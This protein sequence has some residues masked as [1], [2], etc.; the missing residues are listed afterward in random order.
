[1]VKLMNSP[2]FII[3]NPR[4]G[5]TLLRL[6][7]TCHKNILIPPECG[8][9][10][11]W[12]VKYK[13]WGEQGFDENLLFEFIQDLM[14][15]RKIETWGINPEEL[16]KFIEERRPSSYSGL[17]SSVYDWYG[18]SQGKK[19]V[20]WGD[21]NNFYIDH[22]DTIKAIFPEA[23]FIHIVRD[24]RDV[25]C[26]YKKLS[27]QKVDSPYTPNLPREIEEIARQWKNNVKRAIKSFSK[28]GWENVYELKFE[29]LVIDTKDTLQKLCHQLGEEYDPSVLRYHALNMEHELEPKEFLKW[30]G[31]TLKEPI[32]DEVGR[33]S[34]ELTSHELSVFYRVAGEVLSKY[35]YS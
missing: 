13:D 17:V 26:S 35:G 16:F 2:I 20:R 23:F 22:I 15:S 18:L 28:I 29:N 1:M 3:G 9:A 27:E 31:K 33:Y 32:L 14:Q 12:Y 7:L 4:S 25:A 11:W 8:F 30:K 6:M 34:R 5:T 21:K 10:V 24:G 19:F